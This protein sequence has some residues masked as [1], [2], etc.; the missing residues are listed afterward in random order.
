[1]KRARN[2]WVVIGLAAW[3]TTLSAGQFGPESARPSWVATWSAAPQATAPNGNPG[4]AFANETIRQIVRISAGGRSLRVRF[5]NAFGERPLRLGAAH[6]ALHAEE[7]SIVPGSGRALTFGGQP[8]ITVPQGGVVVSDPVFLSVPSLADLAVSLYFPEDTRAS[9]FHNLGN[10]IAYI[11]MP[12][13]FSDATTLPVASTS[14]QRFFLT[15]VEVLPRQNIGA[16]VVIGDS[17]TD[18]GDSLFGQNRRWPDLLSARLNLPN[19]SRLGVAN[20]GIGCGRLLLDYCGPNGSS[21]FDRDVLSMTGVTHVVLALGLVDIILPTSSGRLDEIVSADEIIA[22]MRQLIERAHARGLTIYGAT[23]TPV[24]LSP[25][26]GV[27][28]PENEAKRQAVN[29][30][31]RTSGEFDAVIDFDLAIRD[32]RD[33][34]KMVEDYSSPFG[35]HPNDMGYAVMAASIDLRLFH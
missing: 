19:R 27:F 9:T 6:V 20:Q 21:R 4:R 12:G 17:I 29:H 22:G 10:Q 3:A 5:S 32:P 26:G 31:I 23:I 35:V 18:G 1:M 14:T 28:T 2:I 30:W 25:V 11:S 34:T 33:P 13:D 8:S 7:A 24:G 15:V 16:V